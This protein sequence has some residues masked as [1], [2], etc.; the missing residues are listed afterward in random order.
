M[1][2]IVDTGPILSA[3]DPAD[4]DHELAVSTL[5][6]PGLGLV[7]PQMVVFEAAYLIGARLGAMAESRVLS[8]LGSLEMESP[9]PDDWTRIA[10]IVAQYRDFPIGATDASI[11]ALAERLDTDLVVTFDH[12]HFRAIRPRHVEAFRLL[13]E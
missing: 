8:G 10:E 4:A 13:P 3:A 11:V 6:R 12:R 5:R 2:A 1:L 9:H 7:F